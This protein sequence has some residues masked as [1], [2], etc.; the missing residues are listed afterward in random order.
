MAHHFVTVKPESV[1]DCKAALDNRAA[2]LAIIAASLALIS[3]AVARVD[4]AYA[5]LDRD[6]RITDALN[7]MVRRLEG[8]K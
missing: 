6:V 2:D 3:A 5:T 1:R 8:G 4:H 7:A